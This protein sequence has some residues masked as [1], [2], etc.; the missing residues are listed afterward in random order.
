MDNVS[1]ALALRIVRA[2]SLSDS[3]APDPKWERGSGSGDFNGR[4]T[5]MQYPSV[6]RGILTLLIG[7]T[8]ETW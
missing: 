4:P 2:R 6:Y 7:T 5:H 8:G 1:E 3:K